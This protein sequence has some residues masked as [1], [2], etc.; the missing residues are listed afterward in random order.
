M[1]QTTQLMKAMKKGQRFTAIDALAEFGCF[2]L[3]GR[4]WD[5]KQLLKGTK[6][7]YNLTMIGMKWIYLKKY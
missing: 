1:S 4:A 5:I 3:K 6:L 7:K 2:N